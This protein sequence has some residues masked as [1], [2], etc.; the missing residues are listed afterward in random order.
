MIQTF[1]FYR[2]PLVNCVTYIYLKNLPDYGDCLVRRGTSAKLRERQAGGFVDLGGTRGYMLVERGDGLIKEAQDQANRVMFKT[3]NDAISLAGGATTDPL[4][5]NLVYFRTADGYI[6]RL[7]GTS[8]MSVRDGG[9]VDRP[10][11]ERIELQDGTAITVGRR[12]NYSVIGIKPSVLRKDPGIAAL[13]ANATARIRFS[14]APITE[15]VMV[16][17][18]QAPN[19][20]DASNHISGD[21]D[22]SVSSYFRLSREGR[23]EFIGFSMDQLG[24]LEKGV[25]ASLERRIG[26]IVDAYEG[27]DEAALIIINCAM[28]RGVSSLNNYLDKLEGHYEYVLSV[29]Q[30]KDRDDDSIPEISATHAFF[31]Q[32]HEELGIGG[33]R[34]R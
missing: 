33:M 14:T 27:F 7:R 11:R 17:G 28:E 24:R 29:V 21:F 34:K 31:T 2:K 8:M 12:F 23:N 18:Q 15:I 4:H 6:H 13:G 20:G 25:R 9:H 16:I 19:D 5:G 22:R 10:I 30:P 32:C 1:S 3:S 26:R